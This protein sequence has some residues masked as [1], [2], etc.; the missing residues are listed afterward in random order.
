MITNPIQ[1]RRALLTWQTPLG[2][3]GERRRHAVGELVAAD[4]GARF[5]YLSDTASFSAAIADGFEGYPGIDLETGPSDDALAILLRRLPNSDRPDYDHFLETFGLSP[6]TA[7]SGLSLLAYTGARLAG[8][9][10]SIT[11]TFD[12]F[13]R[14][15]CYIFDVAGFR[16]FMTAAT[17][18]EAGDDVA[19]VHQPDN[20]HDQNAVQVLRED[21]QCLGY[22]NRL[23]SECLLGWQRSGSIS[24]KVFRFNGRPTYPRLFLIADINPSK[25]AKAA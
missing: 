9:S 22:I 3:G 20:A 2:T 4:D 7:W 23:Q 24:A 15:F 10:F 6:D 19:L 14:P 16:R 5:R 21:G 12:G 11:E 18:L 8:D 13:D 25:L 17:G 1:T